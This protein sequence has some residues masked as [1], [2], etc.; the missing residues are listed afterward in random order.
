[1]SWNA[2]LGMSYFAPVLYPL[3]L[4]TRLSH[5]YPNV[6]KNMLLMRFLKNRCFSLS[7]VGALLLPTFPRRGMNS[8]DG[9]APQSQAVVGDLESVRLSKVLKL[10]QAP[11]PRGDRQS[12]K[13]VPMPTRRA[14]QQRLNCAWTGAL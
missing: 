14:A 7:S 12:P 5:T 11:A 4:R 13:A 9:E 6:T 3:L 10:P 2:I 8:K 1:M